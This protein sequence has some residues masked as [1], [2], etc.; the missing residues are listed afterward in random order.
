MRSLNL[1]GEYLNGKEPTACSNLLNFLALIQGDAHVMPHGHL[2]A[3]RLR[4]PFR[5]LRPSYR[6][7][8]ISI[9]SSTSLRK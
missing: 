7:D 8:A 2:L 5:S 1:D 9:L 4:V 6:L 3:C